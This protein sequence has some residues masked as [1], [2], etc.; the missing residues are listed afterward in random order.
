[1]A[2]GSPKTA[3]QSP[4]GPLFLRQCGLRPRVAAPRPSIGAL[5]S[6]QPPVLAVATTLPDAVS[7]WAWALASPPELTRTTQGKTPQFWPA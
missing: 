1:M 3:S 5:F 7:I 6:R 4:L 2:I